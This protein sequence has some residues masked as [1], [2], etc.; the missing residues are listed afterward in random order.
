MD[1]KKY[2][3]LYYFSILGFADYALVV[4]TECAKFVFSRS[5]N[6]Q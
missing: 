1:G 4:K 6:Q 5:T 2:T 3:S